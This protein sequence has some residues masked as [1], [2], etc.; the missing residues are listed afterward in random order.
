MDIKEVAKKYEDYQVE[1]RRYFHKHPEVST[2]E[3]ETSKKIK[4]ELDKINVPWVDC[5]LET[6]VLATIQGGKPGKTIFLRGD[7]DALSVE[8]VTGA[9][10]ASINP[11]V[12]HACGHDTHISMLLTAAHILNDIK[13]EICGTIKLGFQPAE[14]TATGAKAMIED[15]CLEGLDAAFGMHIWSDVPAGT[16]SCMAGPRMASTDFFKITVKGKGCHGAAPH[17]GIDAAV[18]ASSIVMNLQTIVSRKTDPLKPLVLTVGKI[19]AGTRWNVVAENATLEGTTRCFD[20]DI[21]EEIPQLMEDVAKSVAAAYGA[22]AS[23]EMDRLTPP[24]INDPEMTA[25][26]CEAAKK[27]INEN[28]VL[29]TPPTMGGEDFSYYGQKVPASIL[30]LGCRNEELGAVWPQ[31]SGHYCIDE[32]VL[33]T[34]AMTYAQVA[35]DYLNK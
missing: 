10:Y 22:E 2:K 21:Y 24:T 29:E 35:V 17:Q 33:I 25:L 19:E 3:Y 32:S 8:E 16:I 7:I 30:L 26:A 14:E 1:M 18:V 34:G 11:G 15:G 6:G 20:P 23:L 13:D 27:V 28:C 5:G 4:E 12:M 31:H 9:E